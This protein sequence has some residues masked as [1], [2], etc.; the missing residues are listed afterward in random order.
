MFLDFYVLKWHMP[1]QRKN[2]E[3]EWEQIAEMKHNKGILFEE[4]RLNSKKRPNLTLFF[5]LYSEGLSSH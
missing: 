2:Q 1:F 4:E 5:F 3:K